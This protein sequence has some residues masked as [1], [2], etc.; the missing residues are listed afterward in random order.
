MPFHLAFFGRCDI[1]SS[2]GLLTTYI[3][4]GERSNGRTCIEFIAPTPQHAASQLASREKQVDMPTLTIQTVN[5]LPAFQLPCGPSDTVKKLEIAAAARANLLK[6]EFDGG[7]MKLKV[8][9]GAT[10]DHVRL[11]LGREFLV[12][13]D[14]VAGLGLK[15][16]TKLK[17]HIKP[18]KLFSGVGGQAPLPVFSFQRE[19][20]A[21]FVDV[22]TA[23]LGRHLFKIKMVPSDNMAVLLKQALKRARLQGIYPGG[24]KP[25][26]LHFRGKKLG[27]KTKVNEVTGLAAGEELAISGLENDE[28][29]PSVPNS[30]RSTSS[31][32]SRPRTASPTSRSAASS[33][34]LLHSFNSLVNR[35]SAPWLPVGATNWP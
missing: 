8:A 35:P 26:A 12:P 34:R 25:P 6:K 5:G 33:E 24:D 22:V 27:P 19:G 13:S 20:F 7:K 9:T 31:M 23:V 17:L 3:V 16:G 21:F 15:D 2:L 4:S 32:Y 28:P 18:T 14:T 10:L 30:A 1:S 29:P 11:S